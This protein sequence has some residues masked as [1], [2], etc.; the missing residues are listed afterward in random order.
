MVPV[1]LAG[2]YIREL[3]SRYKEE[4]EK[5]KAPDIPFGL[6]LVE[7]EPEVADAEALKRCQRLVG[8]L[9]WVS[10]RTRADVSFGVNK[11]S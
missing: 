3:G 7:P 6:N 1:S 9:L 5:I 11:L 10:V 2:A 8:E 4:L